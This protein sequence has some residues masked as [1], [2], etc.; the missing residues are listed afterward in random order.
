MIYC[1]SILPE[2]RNV[3]NLEWISTFHI[4][5]QRTC[6]H[7]QVYHVIAC[8]L[9]LNEISTLYTCIHASISCH[10]HLV[11]ACELN[12]ISTLYIHHT[13]A[14]ISCQAH[15]VIACVSSFPVVGVPLQ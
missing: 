3:R 10:A 13:C 9:K 8:E 12:E 11:I 6:V 14:S 2:L 15:L 4:H 5:V 7:V 1:G